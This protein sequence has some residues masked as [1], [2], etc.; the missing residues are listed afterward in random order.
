MFTFLR[1]IILFCVFMMRISMRWSIFCC[2]VASMRWR[3]HLALARPVSS[4]QAS[5]RASAAGFWR[6]LAFIWSF[7]AARE[8]FTLSAPF[9]SLQRVE[10]VE[11]TS[12]VLLLE[13][14]VL[15]E[16][17]DAAA[18]LLELSA[19]ASGSELIRSDVPRNRERDFFMETGGRN[20]WMYSITFY[21]CPSRSLCAQYAESPPQAVGR[22]GGLSGRGDPPRRRCCPSRLPP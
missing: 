20:E 3:R 7:A 9:R 5:M 22:W 10:K 6:N 13:D 1:I 14:E 21:R 11:R 12:R 15:E 16:A 18:E 19:N 8:H 2:W 4:L 17:K